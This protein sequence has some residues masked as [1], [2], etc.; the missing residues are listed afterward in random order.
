MEST[1]TG[2]GYGRSFVVTNPQPVLLT[3]GVPRP[4]HPYTSVEFGQLNPFR[5]PINKIRIYG[6]N[7]RDV[8]DVSPDISARVIAHGGRGDDTI[9]GGSGNDWLYGGAGVNTLYGRG[10]HDRIVGGRQTDYIYGGTGNDRIYGGPGNDRLHGDGGIDLLHG[11][12]GDDHI[13]GGNHRDRLFG[14]IGNDYLY[15][16]GGADYL[17]GHSG[18]D[19]LW[20]SERNSW[21]NAVDRLFG[22]WHKVADFFYEDI[23]GRR[24]IM[25]TESTDR[26][27]LNW[28]V[29]PPPLS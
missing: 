7:G 25:R 27:L 10:G 19:H 13:W 11:H 21:D 1:Y 16:G 18:D 2:G 8:I 4:D 14:G 24:D 9:Y 17:W 6:K 28:R 23:R 20:G 22:Q 12:A 5:E 3:P 29:P 15:G 26:V